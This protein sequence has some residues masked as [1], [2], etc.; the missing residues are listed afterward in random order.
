MHVAGETS[1]LQTSILSHMNQKG[2]GTNILTIS[3][4]GLIP[5]A[6]LEGETEKK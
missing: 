6:V 4:G 2:V 3:Q 1:S 5:M